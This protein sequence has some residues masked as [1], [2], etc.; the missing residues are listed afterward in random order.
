MLS[1]HM[2]Q[3]AVLVSGCHDK[4][5]REFDLRIPIS[6]VNGHQEHAKPVLCLA[7]TEQYVYS[8]SEDKT[9]CVWDRRA[10]QQLQKIKVTII[11]I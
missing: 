11:A 9:V 7:A 1:L 4:H 8:G 6:V 10:Q 3:P 2:P 5:V